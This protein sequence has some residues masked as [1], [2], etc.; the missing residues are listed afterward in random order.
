MRQCVLALCVA[1]CL[2]ACSPS[3]SFVQ[4]G[5]PQPARA[6]S[7]PVEVFLTGVP[8]AKYSELGVMEVRGGNLED[9]VEAAKAEARVRGGN[10]IVLVGTSSGLTATRAGNAASASTYDISTFA[11][12]LL[13]R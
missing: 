9:R 12:V 7:A 3:V 6:I 10:G 1:L 13:E 8:K 11:V 2:G 4:T 5:S